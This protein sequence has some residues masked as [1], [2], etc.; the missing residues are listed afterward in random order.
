MQSIQRKGGDKREVLAL[1]EGTE[2]AY[3]QGTLVSAQYKG[4]EAVVCDDCGT[5]AVQIW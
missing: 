5:P 1:V 4:N 2:C 3:C